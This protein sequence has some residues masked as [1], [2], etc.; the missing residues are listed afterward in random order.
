[1]KPALRD[2]PTSA[3]Y[4]ERLDA[5]IAPCSA[6]GRPARPSKVHDLLLLLKHV[7]VLSDEQVCARWVI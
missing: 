7:F 4:W 1:M 5:E 2:E 3:V 6:K